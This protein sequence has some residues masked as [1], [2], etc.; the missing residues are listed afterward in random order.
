M[1]VPTDATR[2]GDFEEALT[3]CLGLFGSL[4]FTLQGRIIETSEA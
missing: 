2:S 3:A 1:R 4:E